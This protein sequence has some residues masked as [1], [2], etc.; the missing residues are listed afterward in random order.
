M[1][2]LLAITVTM[3]GCGTVVVRDAVPEAAVDEVMILGRS[4][5]RFRPIRGVDL[6]ADLQEA[7]AARASQQ[8]GTVDFLALSGGGANGAFGAG[9]LAGWT[10]TGTRP[11][12]GVVSGVSTGA[13]TAPF[14]FLGSA[15]DATLRDLYTTTSTSD[16]A[17]M[18]RLFSLLRADAAADSAGLRDLIVQYV[19]AP[20]LA[21]IAAEHARGR[22]LYVATTDL[23]AGEPV[24]W[25]MG[26]IASLADRRALGL[27][28]D[29]LLASAAIPGAFSPVYIDVEHAG[30]DYREMHVD[31]GVSTQVFV[32]PGALPLAPGAAKEGARTWRVWVIRNSRLLV[33]HE[34]VQPRILAIAK[35]SVDMLIKTQ[36]MGD[37]VRIY[38]RSRRED[39]DF[40]LAVIPMDFREEAAESFDPVY[41]RKLYA[42][43]FDAAAGGYPWLKHAPG[44]APAETGP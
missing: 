4:D 8:P 3:A 2:S 38:A 9:L 42:L 18:R 36:G 11:E 39:V 5:L 1:A 22:R 14:A 13:L 27:F 30:R 40:N 41:M 26:R 28:R 34:E 43:G 44:F 33:D 25:D 31:G 24:I 17:F 6:A 32:L 10:Q 20:L 35:R 21:A 37:I 16:V 29:V 23:D 12:F 15:Y 19:D 7:F